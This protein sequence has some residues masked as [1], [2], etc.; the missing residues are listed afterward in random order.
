MKKNFRLDIQHYNSFLL[1]YINK[2]KD[3][4]LF[5]SGSSG[6]QNMHVVMHVVG[7]YQL[8]VEIFPPKSEDHLSHEFLT[9]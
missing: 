4:P 9:C 7:I 6:Q 2:N 5:S 1:V 8:G 3:L